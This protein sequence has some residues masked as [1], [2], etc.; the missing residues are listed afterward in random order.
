[1]NKILLVALFFA[2]GFVFLGSFLPW[3]SFK[4]QL[5]AD[6]PF[7]PDAMKAFVAEVMTATGWK[8]DVSLFGITIP[9]W[10]VPVAAIFVS[11]TT[12]FRCAGTWNTP[13][14]L[15]IGLAVFCTVHLGTL[16]VVAVGNSE[17]TRLGFGAILGMI[18]SL[19]MLGLTIFIREDEIETMSATTGTSHDRASEVAPQGLSQPSVSQ[20]GMA[21]PVMPDQAPTETDPTPPS[22]RVDP[23]MD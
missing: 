1:M 20:P 2:S 23:H 15:S 5:P 12:A 21:Q 11:L 3:L 14:G 7:D 10:M 19:G 16:L 18:G 8:G 6:I 22:G 13:R 4:A 9:N 17:T